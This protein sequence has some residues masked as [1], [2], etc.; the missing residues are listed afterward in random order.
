MASR[1]RR[2]FEPSKKKVKQLEFEVKVV[3]GINETG[4]SS[5]RPK[6]LNLNDYVQKFRDHYNVEVVN[7]DPSR[8]A[9]DQNK[10]YVKF[11][12]RLRDVV[13]KPSAFDQIRKTWFSSI[14]EV[15]SPVWLESCEAT[16][17]SFRFKADAPR[18]S[19][20]PTSFSLGS[21]LDRGTFVEHY[22]TES[23]RHLIEGQSI[24]AEFQHDTKVLDISFYRIDGQEVRLT[25]EYKQF[26]DYILVDEINKGITKL[27]VPLVR[28][29]KVIRVGKGRRY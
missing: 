8:I 18:Q 5:R 17:N 9:Q 7:S 4:P 27:Y 12:L 23:D 11:K 22:N 19:L 20:E 10:Q 15:G 16:R 3:G 6:T 21:F 28:P 2:A 14:C 24:Y 13:L 26:E 29:P 1:R 25:F